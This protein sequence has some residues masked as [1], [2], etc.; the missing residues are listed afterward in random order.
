MLF[1]TSCCQFDSRVGGGI[2]YLWRTALGK[3][4]SKHRSTFH[5]CIFTL[6]TQLAPLFPPCLSPTAQN[7]IVSSSSAEGNG[8]SREFISWGLYCM[9]VCP[10]CSGLGCSCSLWVWLAQG[11]SRHPNNDTGVL[12]VHTGC[13]GPTNVFY[14]MREGKEW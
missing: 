10:G 8:L 2:R 12:C 4:G 13:K 14:V 6:Q 1:A 9:M 11:S 5:T 3:V 7:F